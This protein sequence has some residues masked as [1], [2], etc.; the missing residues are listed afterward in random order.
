MKSNPNQSALIRYKALK[1]LI[2]VS[3]TTIFRWERDLT[4]PRHFKLG[5]NSVAWRLSEVEEWIAQKQ[6]A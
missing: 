2:G 4:F 5:G 6:K 3:R 1:E